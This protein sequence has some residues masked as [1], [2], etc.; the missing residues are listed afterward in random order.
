MG[1]HR[2]RAGILTA[3]NLGQIQPPNFRGGQSRWATFVPPSHPGFPGC[4]LWALNLGDPAHQLDLRDQIR[5]KLRLVAAERLH[6]P[7]VVGAIPGWEDGGGS[8][9]PHIN[10]PLE[11]ISTAPGRTHGRLWGAGERGRCHRG[12]PGTLPP[13][14]HSQL[15]INPAG[16]KG[17]RTCISGKAEHLQSPLAPSLLPPL[18]PPV[19][20]SPPTSLCGATLGT[21]ERAWEMALT[22]ILQWLREAVSL[23]YIRVRSD[24][25]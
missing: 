18:H 25:L 8:T 7:S 4:R 1:S 22:C 12:Q 21:Y 24:M 15:S 10:F 5:M 23:T 11:G 19:L 2:F 3:W 17:G 16:L 13:H 6:Q 9:S 14:P 20:S